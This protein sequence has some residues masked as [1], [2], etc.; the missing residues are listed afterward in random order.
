MRRPSGFAGFTVLWLGQLL[1]AVGTRMTNFAISIWVFEETGRTFDLAML[2]FCAFGATVVFSPI[3]GVLIDRLSRRLTIMLSDIG[4]AVTTAAVLLLFLSGSVEVWQL[5][6]VNIVTGAFLAFQLPAYSATITLMMDKGR[7]PRANAMMFAVRFGPQI[8]APAGAAALLAGA[9]IEAVLLID[10]F[11]YVAAVLTVLLVAIPETPVG[12]AVDADGN[13]E[14]VFDSL[15]FG[16]RYIWRRPGLLGLEG[17]LFSIGLLSAIGYVMLAPLVLARTGNDETALGIV[18]AVGAVGGVAG[19]LLIGI[20]RPARR[21]MTWII[22]GILIFSLIGRIGYGTAETVAVWAVALVFTH[23][24]IPF[25]D[26]YG[27]S[28]WQEKVEPAVQGRVFGARQFIENLALPIGMFIAGPVTDRFFEPEMQPGG[29]LAGTFSWLVGTGP[30]AGM[31]L[32]CV[33]VG[34]LGVGVAAGAAGWRQ[35]RDIETILPDHDAVDEPVE[36]ADI[37]VGPVADDA[38]SQPQPEGVR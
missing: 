32:V 34:V 7:Y 6:L 11:S 31:G 2:M 13:R 5:Y 25:I 8:L 38:V 14:S 29:S 18:Q 35:V 10:A 33:L 15:L 12:G 28:I 30:G 17:I 22:G 23:I 24:A 21:K 27:Q 3:A 4:S 16:F 19:A 20:V 26:G 9:S 37:P 36:P 1:S